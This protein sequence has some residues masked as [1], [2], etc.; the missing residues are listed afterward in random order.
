MVNRPAHFVERTDHDGPYLDEVRD[1]EEKAY[2]ETRQSKKTK[3]A[4]PDL[5]N[6]PDD[7]NAQRVARG[8]VLK[9]EDVKPAKKKPAK[10]TAAKKSAS[11]TAKKS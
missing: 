7:G 4:T 2:R 11:S 5:S 8:E 3:V 1:A 6:V 9:E 10:K